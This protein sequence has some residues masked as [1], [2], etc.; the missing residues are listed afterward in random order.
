[1]VSLST[2]KLGDRIRIKG[3]ELIGNV[4]VPTGGDVANCLLYQRYNN[5]D[6]PNT[7]AGEVAHLYEQWIPHRY[8]YE[9]IP[10]VPTG[11]QAG[12][13]V[14]GQITDPTR[15]L[16]SG[17]SGLASAIRVT[18]GSSMKQ[19]WQP[20]I[21]SLPT[22]KKYTALW[23]VDPDPGSVT[24]NDRLDL[25]GQVA[26]VTVTPGNVAAGTAIAAIQLHY[27][28]EFFTPRLSLSSTSKK[29]TVRATRTDAIKTGLLP[30]LTGDTVVSPLNGFVATL[31]GE[32]KKS[33]AEAIQSGIKNFV[34][35]NLA[36]LTDDMS[37]E[38][39]HSLLR[40][41]HQML[42]AVN[43]PADKGFPPGN[44]IFTWT[45]YTN[46][47]P[48]TV[49]GA[50]DTNYPLDTEVTHFTYMKP[51]PAIYTDGV[52]ATGCEY[53]NTDL[54]SAIGA[55]AHSL[56]PV[57][58]F[59]GVNPLDDPCTQVGFD[60]EPVVDPLGVE[61][62][63]A[64]SYTIEFAATSNTERCFADVPIL[65]SDAFVYAIPTDT[66]VYA[67]L[68]VASDSLVYSTGFLAAKQK[69]RP[70]PRPRRHLKLQL[71]SD[72]PLKPETKE[73]S[74]EEKKTPSAPMSP[75]DIEEVPVVFAPKYK[76]TPSRTPG[77]SLY[78]AGKR[79]FPST[80]QSST[81]K[82]AK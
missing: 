26:M 78:S 4:V 79:V 68:A 32:T 18:P 15:E 23:T 42:G 73:E 67:S 62:K 76:S 29:T 25:A 57:G 56:R 16:A 36:S 31:V 11:T 20:A 75:F 64:E 63:W 9:I 51:V 55:R 44:Y 22:N 41:Q 60:F 80:S 45:M 65:R 33:A 38:E 7:R 58:T 10:S 12:T 71:E 14:F 30:P 70:L 43:S 1:M 49:D 8:D 77:G 35:S 28:I 59:V 72:A 39:Y 54:N 37:T 46:T 17:A 50:T 34:A 21:A 47:R 52:F 74:K 53:Y 61:W 27:D 48:W 82:V 19:Y 66:V 81:D 13:Y 6:P 3:T 2:G 69:S 24:G 40:H 5:A